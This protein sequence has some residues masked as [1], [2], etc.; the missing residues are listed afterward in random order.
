MSAGRDVRIEVSEEAR[1]LH[2]ESLVVD[3]HTDSFIAVKIL[4]LDYGERHQPP[5]GVQ[6]WKL[7]ADKPRLADG[8]VDAVFF[9][10]VTYPLPVGA[11]GRA[12]KSVEFAK[13]QFSE[14]GIAFARTPADIEAARERGEIAGLMGL[15]GLHMLSGEPRRLEELFDQGVRYTGLT[16]FTSNVFATSSASKTRKHARLGSKGFEALEICDSLGMMVDLAHVHTDIIN[17]VCIRARK[18]VIVSHGGVRAVRDVFRNLTDRDINSV[19]S[20]D[21]VIG[22]MYASHWLAPPRTRPSLSA[23]VDH[24]DHVRKLVSSRHLALGSDWDGMIETPA[25][26]RGADDL[27]A[28]TQ[29]FLERGYTHDEVRGILGGNFMR[30][31][32]ANLD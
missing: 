1:K 2:E 9:G 14:T 17:E 3:L 29:L 30:V 20:T 28:L 18:P 8:G 15:E 21:G 26:M 25:G 10:I 24:A 11:F 27:P 16:H 5:T 13:R 4:R 31:F 7:H 22:L 32:K 12:L 23:V 6:P 19:A